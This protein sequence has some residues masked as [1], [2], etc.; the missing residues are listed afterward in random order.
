[1]SALNSSEPYKLT[2]R[3]ER[4]QPITKTSNVAVQAHENNEYSAMEYSLRE[5]CGVG[6]LAARIL[7]V[8]SPVLSPERI[9]SSK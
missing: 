8:D 4:L 5:C 3:F 2:I 7:T 1:M 9:P 6:S